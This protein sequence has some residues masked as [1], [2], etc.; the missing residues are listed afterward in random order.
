[1]ELPVILKD[2]NVEAAA[3]LLRRYYL[4]PSTTTGLLSTGSYFDE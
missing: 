2:E 4:E 1:M 3:G